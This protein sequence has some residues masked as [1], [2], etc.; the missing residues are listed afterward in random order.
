SEAYSLIVQATIGCSNNSCT[1]CSMYKDKKFR[2]RPTAD[3]IADLREARGMYR[4]VGRVFL[5]DG[6]ALVL[7]A[8]RLLVL[9]AEVRALFPECGRVSIY[10]TPQAVLRKTPEELRKLAGAGLAI[11]YIGAESGDDEV[12]MRIA[13][14]AT[15]DET[16]AAIR[17][18]EDAGIAAS[19][20]FISGLG[21]EPLSEKHASGCARV[22]TESRPSYAALLTLLLEPGAPM[23]E[24]L[25]KGAFFF[26]TPEQIAEETLLLL[27]LARPGTDCVFRSN[28]ASNYVPLKGTLPHDNERLIETLKAALADGAFKSDHFRLL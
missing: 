27:D 8:D 12:L 3:V 24:D 4:N 20:T 26:M 23:Y 16:I 13:K 2:A 18:L 7:S 21:G 19:V 10:G 17:K 1:F 5:A 28:H 11:V 14:G 9:L 22:I 6:D 15:A 25:R